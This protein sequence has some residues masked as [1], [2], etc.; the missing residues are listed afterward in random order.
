MICLCFPFLRPQPQEYNE[1]PSLSG[2]Y[3]A[4]M[5]L[6]VQDEL[7]F[8]SGIEVHFVRFPLE[9]VALAALFRGAERRRNFQV[10]PP[11]DLVYRQFLQRGNIVPDAIF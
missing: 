1:N 11:L 5:T 4:E 7:T 8:P 2:T 10:S 3:A 6:L 9:K